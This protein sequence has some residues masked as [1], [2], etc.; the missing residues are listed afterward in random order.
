M[1]DAEG[2]DFLSLDPENDPAVPFHHLPV[3]LEPRK[4]IYPRRTRSFSTE[5]K[6]LQAC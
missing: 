5:F 1:T 3:S 4:S 6:E 2:Q